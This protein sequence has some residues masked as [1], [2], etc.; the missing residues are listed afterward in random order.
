VATLSAREQRRFVA[1]LRVSTEGQSRSG[2]GLDAQRQAAATYL[3]QHGGE[4]LAE[5]QEAL[6]TCW[7]EVTLRRDK[8]GVLAAMPKRRRR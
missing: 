2:L 6:S 8:S 3:A 7:I 1:Y 5:F 4:L